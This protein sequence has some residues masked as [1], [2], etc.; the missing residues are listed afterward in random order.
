MLPCGV[1]AATDPAA[2]PGLLQQQQGVAEVE[3]G[4]TYHT[5]SLEVEG[6][7]PLQYVCKAEAAHLSSNQL[8]TARPASDGD[9]TG[10]RLSPAARTIVWCGGGGGGPGS[11]ARVWGLVPAKPGSRIIL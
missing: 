6:E 5:A 4:V 10:G 1:A 7:A 2:P 9:A 8:R 11:P 3:G